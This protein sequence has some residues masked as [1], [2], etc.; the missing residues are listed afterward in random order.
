MLKINIKIMLTGDDYRL[1]LKY[2]HYKT[3]NRI[4]ILV[5]STTF[6]CIFHGEW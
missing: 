4:I 6:L 5:V 3:P 1:S 2:L